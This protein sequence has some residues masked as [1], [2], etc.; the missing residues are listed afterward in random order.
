MATQEQEEKKRAAQEAEVTN[1]SIAVVS[2]V[3]IAVWFAVLA[4]LAYYTLSG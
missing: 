1:R 4:V 3:V 2:Y